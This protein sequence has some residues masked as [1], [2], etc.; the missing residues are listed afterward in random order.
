MGWDSR[1][2]G[3]D[4][5]DLLAPI[6]GASYGGPVTVVAGGRVRDGWEP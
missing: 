4:K 3:G 6:E 1:G 2:F 5:T